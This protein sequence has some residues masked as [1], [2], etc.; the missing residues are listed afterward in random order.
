MKLWWMLIPLL[1]VNLALKV[2]G[3]GPWTVQIDT[4]S[5]GKTDNGLADV[6][7]HTPVAQHQSSDG[8]LIRLPCGEDQDTCSDFVQAMNDGYLKRKGKQHDEHEYTFPNVSA[9]AR[10]LKLA[11][12]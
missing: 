5:Y 2:W 10:K 4:A 7:V 6:E 8:S 3:T 1:L 9:P 11:P 12:E